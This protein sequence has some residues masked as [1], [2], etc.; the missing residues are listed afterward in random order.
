MAKQSTL[1]PIFDSPKIGQYIARYLIKQGRSQSLDT[2][3]G[4]N[5][6][7]KYVEV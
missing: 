1:H 2:G 7:L 5:E 6:G 4:L 3:F